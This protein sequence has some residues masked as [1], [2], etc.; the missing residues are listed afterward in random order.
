MKYL[1]DVN[2]LSEPTKLVVS[3]RVESWL[4]ANWSECVVNVVVMAEIGRG[5]DIMPDGKRKSALAIWFAD[6]QAAIPCLDWTMETALLW[7]PIVNHVKSS[8]F[9]IGMPDTMIAA[10]AKQHGLVVATRN[11]ADFTRC[12]VKAFNPFE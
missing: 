7:G 6:L 8:G 10:S 4:A 1:V 5:I 2:V 12:G 11:V 9:T 3:K